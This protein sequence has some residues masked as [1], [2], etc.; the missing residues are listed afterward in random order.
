MQVPNITLLLREILQV[1]NNLII[2]DLLKNNYFI[3]LKNEFWVHGPFI[4]NILDDN[5]DFLKIYWMD[6]T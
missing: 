6:R 5:K 3:I 2:S 4:K 1:A